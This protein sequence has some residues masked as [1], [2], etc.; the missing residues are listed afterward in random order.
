MSGC[1]G[2]SLGTD[3]R[4]DLPWS[5]ERF[6]AYRAVEFGRVW[7][8]SAGL[9]RWACYPVVGPAMA[10]FTDTRLPAAFVL[11]SVT[12]GSATGTCRRVGDWE[13]KP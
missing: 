12:P 8:G 6:W 5:V 11:A 13:G 2:T 3:P 4:P 9:S 1:G 7:R 10:V